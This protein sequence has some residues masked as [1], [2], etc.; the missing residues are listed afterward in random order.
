M[1]GKL[2]Q[3]LTGHGF[4]NRHNFLVFG[5]N[6]EEVYPECDLCGGINGK[7]PDQTFGHIFAE[8]P[9]FFE[10]RAQIFGVYTLDPPFIYPKSKIC[11]FL[12]ETGIEELQWEDIEEE[13]EAPAVPSST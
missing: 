1:W 10:I 5:P 13:E 9:I 11:Q 8:C 7:A 3:S 2:M 6:D 4:L 12:K